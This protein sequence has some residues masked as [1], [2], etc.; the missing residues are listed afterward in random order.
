MED[1]SDGDIIFFGT[2][3]CSDSVLNELL[4]RGKSLKPGSKILSLKQPSSLVLNSNQNEMKN[5][6]NR[7]GNELT[8]YGSNPYNYQGEN[9]YK[10]SSSEN[11]ES[12]FSLEQ[13]VW[14]T[15]SWGRARVYILVRNS[16]P[17]E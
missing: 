12:Y 8:E 3:L 11:D 1:W 2:P 16:N 15:F 17:S 13:D 4:V 7:R 10:N 9:E 14:C 5:R 6:A